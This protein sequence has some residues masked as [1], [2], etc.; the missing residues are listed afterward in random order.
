MGLILG[1]QKSSLIVSFPLV[2]FLGSNQNLFSSFKFRMQ[3]VFLSG[4]FRMK[5]KKVFEMTFSGFI[6]FG[7]FVKEEVGPKLKFE[8]LIV[9][10][11]CH[12]E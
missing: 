4:S 9:S 2:T 8:V 12:L 11:L 3:R 10:I 7:T 6:C 1:W 5:N